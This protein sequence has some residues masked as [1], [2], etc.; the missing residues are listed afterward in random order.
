M[1]KGIKSISGNASADP[2]AWGVLHLT[3]GAKMLH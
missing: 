1:A 3:S 2:R